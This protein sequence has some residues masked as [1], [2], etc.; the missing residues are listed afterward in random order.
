MGFN[1]LIHPYEH[2]Y[3]DANEVDIVILLRGLERY[4]VNPNHINI[5]WN[6]SHPDDISIE[7]YEDFDIVFIASLGFAKKINSQTNTIVR[8]L[9]Q[10]T[11]STSFFPEKNEYYS[12]DILF[13]GNTRGVFR[14]AIKNINQTNHNFSVYGGGDWHKFIDKDYIKGEFIP[15]SDLNQAYSS[16][17]ILLNDH[18]DDMRI[19]DFPSNRL[20]DA[21]ASEAFIIS[22][23][24]PSVDSI[25]EG[26][27]ITYEN[28]DDLNSKINYYLTHEKERKLKSKKGR[29]IVLKNHTF[30]KRAKTIVNYIKQLDDLLEK[31][32][33]NEIKISIIIPVFNAEKYLGECLDSVLSQ[34]IKDI[35]VLCIDHGSTD[36]SYGVMEKYAS[37]DARVKIFSI[38]NEKRGAGAPRNVGLENAKGKYIHFLDP[39][40]WVTKDGYEKL[41]IAAEENNL[42]LLLFKIMPYINDTGRTF[43]N[44]AFEFISIHNLEG[45]IFNINDLGKDILDL[46][47]SS[48]NKLIRQDFIKKINA[49][50]PEGIFSQDH[51]FTFQLY[52]NAKRISFINDYFYYYRQHPSSVTAKTGKK[53]FDYITARNVVFNVFKKFNYFDKFKSELVNQKL[54][55]LNKLYWRMSEEYIEEFFNLLKEDFINMRDVEKIDEDLLKSI[56]PYNKE[57]YEKVIS[58]KNNKEFS[59]QTCPICGNIVEKFL[60]LN[61]K[62]V[63]CPHCKSVPRQRLFYLFF[64]NFTT[65]FEKNNKLLYFDPEYPIHSAFKKDNRIK[66]FSV[67]SKNN[68][69]EL[70]DKQINIE[71]MPFE[72]DE[73]DLIYIDSPIK[74]ELNTLSSSSELFRVIKPYSEG[75][76][77]VLRGPAF[78]NL[79]ESSL[80]SAGFKIKKYSANDILSPY[81]LNQYNIDSNLKIF[82]CMK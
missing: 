56:N 75:G 31:E 20:F 48:V 14:N 73:F 22:D 4:T 61:D 13:V 42:D 16:C 62:E 57:F 30:N 68:T 19:K 45:K 35:E 63:R 69:S 77:L 40:D 5:M 34:S 24:F 74:N 53:Q 43:T 7:E 1:V 2:F 29:E 38:S 12:N 8:P 50:F 18:W 65:I 54:D 47:G 52:L 76:L 58:S 25:F 80:I 33:G 32:K 55:I 70:V 6:I 27:L 46:S 44:P 37:L 15:N 82:V 78:N 3:N 60:V 39:D 36:N 49:R 81:K 71:Q 17:K 11:D 72:D 23:D 64:K 9:L 79:D 28:A 10:C 51:A 66:L 41:Y 26:N 59:E 67:S 21:F